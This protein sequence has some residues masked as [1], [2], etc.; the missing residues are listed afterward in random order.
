MFRG[1]GASPTFFTGAH[2][3]ITAQAAAFK[4]TN[5]RSQ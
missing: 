1:V 4:R 3:G 2:I 5:L